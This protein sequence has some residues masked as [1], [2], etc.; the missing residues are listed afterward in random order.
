MKKANQ[1]LEAIHRLK[2]SGE[3]LGYIWPYAAL[4]LVCTLL[5]LMA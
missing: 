1:R 4:A 2:M 5:M 3:L